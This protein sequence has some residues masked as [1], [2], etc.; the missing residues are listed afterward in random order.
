MSCGGHR[1]RFSLVGWESTSRVAYVH[2]TAWGRRGGRRGEGA[3]RQPNLITMPLIPSSRRQVASS[4]APFPW[5]S[6]ARTQSGNA[7]MPSMLGEQAAYR[8]LFQRRQPVHEL[9]EDLG[10][11]PSFSRSTAQKAGDR[12][13]KVQA[14]RMGT[15]PTPH[16][17]HG[18]VPDPQPTNP[19]GSGG[20]S[21]EVSL[22]IA[23]GL[24][25]FLADF[26]K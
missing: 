8:L 16:T 10:G 9:P 12:V 17:S 18:S 20:R 11:H 24:G 23:S 13:S 19:G 4:L 26:L 1:V 14:V 3:H 21:G 15:A 5:L 6:V 22:P 2:L 25:A 7:A